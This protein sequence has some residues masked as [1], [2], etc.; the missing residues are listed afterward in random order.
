MFCTSC[1]SSTWLAGARYCGRC[2]APLQTPLWSDNSFSSRLELLEEPAD[3]QRACPRCGKEVPVDTAYCAFCGGR[4]AVG[5]ASGSHPA[6]E[7]ERGH[8]A[9]AL[10]EAR[11]ELAGGRVRQARGQCE[12]ALALDSRNA[13]AHA[14]MADIYNQEGSIAGAL[15]EMTVALRLDPTNAEYER[16]LRA[17]REEQDRALAPILRTLGEP[18]PNRPRRRPQ[19][20]GGLRVQPARRSLDLNVPDWAKAAAL[21]GAIMFVLWAVPA[22]LMAN[23]QWV[24]GLIVGVVAAMWVYRDARSLGMGLP[25]AL[26]WAVCVAIPLVGLAGLLIYLLI[27]RVRH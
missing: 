18:R 7:E 9:A 27:T 11:E 13:E 1:K 25:A 24:L 10:G 4:F 12:Q 8:A 2:G 3:E 6:S 22:G 14:L 17:L 20:R 26:F 5:T 15:Q 16:R 21:I 23:L 19:P